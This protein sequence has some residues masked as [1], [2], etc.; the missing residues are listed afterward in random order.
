LFKATIEVALFEFYRKEGYAELLLRQHEA[1]VDAIARRE[2]E[3][4]RLRMVEHLTIVEQ[5][6]SQLL[7]ERGH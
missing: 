2:P 3:E 4:A 1:I 5:K 7:E 6:L